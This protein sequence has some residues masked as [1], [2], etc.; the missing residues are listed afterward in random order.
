M[1]NDKTFIEKLM[2]RNKVL[3]DDNVNMSDKINSLMEKVHYL[4]KDNWFLKDKLCIENG[5]RGKCEK[6]G[7]VSV[8]SLSKI[9]EVK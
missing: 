8:V 1:S 9:R 7:T 3:K 5:S 4:E 6:C 2:A